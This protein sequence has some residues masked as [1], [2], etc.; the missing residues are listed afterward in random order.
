MDLLPHFIRL[1]RPVA[2][3]D[4][5][6]LPPSASTGL[7]GVEESLRDPPQVLALSWREDH[8]SVDT[9][10]RFRLAAVGGR[11]RLTVIHH[12]FEHLPVQMRQKAVKEY[13]AGRK[14][15]IEVLRALLE[16]AGAARQGRVPNSGE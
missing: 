2:S 12:G 9:F 13:E 3:G 1:T 10:V 11:T 16:G 14:R 4:G 5:Q 6:Q 15:G 7:R 8:W